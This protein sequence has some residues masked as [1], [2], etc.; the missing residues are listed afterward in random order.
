MDTKT[1]EKNWAELKGKIKSKWNK[2]S[3]EEIESIKGDLNQLAGKVQ[4]TYGI[5]KDQADHQYEEFKKSMQ[6]LIGQ[7]ETAVN[8]TSLP[9]PN[10]VIAPEKQNKTG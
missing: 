4:K 7:D 1:I 10:L 5:A 6:S 8:S 2:F 3:D 9:K